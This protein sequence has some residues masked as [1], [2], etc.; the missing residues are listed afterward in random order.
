[1]VVVGFDIDGERGACPKGKV[2]RYCSTIAERAASQQETHM[3]RG[4]PHHLDLTVTD[5]PRSIAFY[6]KVLGELGYARS[7]EYAGDVPCWMIG[8]GDAV[9][10]IGLH[11]ARSDSV[12]DR[13]A[14]GFHHLALGAESRAAVDVFHA[15]LLHE[16][17]RVLD[18]PAEYDYTPG[19]YAVFFA[20]PDG[21]KLELVHEP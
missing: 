1:L 16:E 14:A 2:K 19:Y 10:S 12:H 13:Y 15:F 21:L 9:F 7:D 3:S 4:F 6:D 20:D 5:L 11:V 17:I 8:E 18:A